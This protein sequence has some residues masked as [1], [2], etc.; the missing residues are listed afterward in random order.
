MRY[1]QL[2]DAGS[3]LAL[4]V[5]TCEETP[6]LIELRGA[7]IGKALHAYGTTG[8]VVEVELALAPAYPW[9]EMVAAFE[10]F[11]AAA[12]F[13]QAL[14]SSDGLFLK[15]DSLMAWPLP[16]YFRGLEEA[17]ARGPSRRHD[18]GGGRRRERRDGAR[19]RA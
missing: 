1:G 10:D 6:R 17:P 4:K 9:I 5:V 13:A 12:R 11:G 2:R 16:R 7:D 8:I 15:L 14:A 19:R 18:H 3:V